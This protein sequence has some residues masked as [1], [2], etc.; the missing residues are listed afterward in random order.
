MEAM[1]APTTKFCNKKI[2]FV[3]FMMRTREAAMQSNGFQFH[4]DCVT[5]FHHSIYVRGWF[6]HKTDPLESVE[7]I[8]S[9]VQ[10]TISH[11]GTPHAAATHLGSN[12]GFDIQ[13]LRDTPDFDEA[14]KII[15]RS[16]SGK[17]LRSGLLFI[18]RHAEQIGKYTRLLAEFKEMAT[19]RMLDVGGRNLSGVDRARR[20]PGLDVTVL[21]I[22]PGDDVEVVGDAHDLSTFFPANH[23]DAVYSSSVFE[24]LMAPW[25]VV[26]EINKVL[27]PGGLGLVQSHQTKGLHNTPWDF[28]RFSD[29]A[30]KALFNERTGFEIIGTALDRPHHIVPHYFS[31]GKDNAEAEVGFEASAV[32]FRKIGPGDV[33]WMTALQDIDW[34]S[35]TPDEPAALVPTLTLPKRA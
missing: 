2:L 14:A 29:T 32:L 6:Y 26:L 3:N 12:L 21:D 8:C 22:L 20:F 18:T 4:I 33:Q 25:K 31:S 34:R 10:S 7:L 23:F 13:I 17:I 1:D 19:G 35:C 30:W 15:F 28:W 27:K 16:T 24:H 5:K 9:G 11:V